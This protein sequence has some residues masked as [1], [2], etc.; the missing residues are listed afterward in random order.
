MASLIAS[1]TAMLALGVNPRGQGSSMTPHV[2]H[3]VGKPAKFRVGVGSYA[4]NVGDTQMPGHL[5]YLKHLP[6]LAA[7]GEGDHDVVVAHQPQV[8]VRRLGRMNESAGVA[9][10]QRVAANLRAIW[11][12]LPIPVVNTLPEQAANVSTAATKSF[13][14]STARMASASALSTAR[15]RSC[16]WHICFRTRNEHGVMSPVEC[17]PQSR[18]S[19]FG[20]FTKHFGEDI[21]KFRVSASHAV[22]IRIMP[23]KIRVRP[24]DEPRLRPAR[25]FSGELAS[26]DLFPCAEDS[27]GTPRRSECVLP[28]A[29]P[30]GSYVQR[31][32]SS[33]TPFGKP[34]PSNRQLSIIRMWA[35]EAGPREMLTAWVQRAYSC[36]P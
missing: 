32:K 2:E 22:K 35:Q 34:R 33:T 25:G 17:K 18:T 4:D 20:N 30:A 13:V 12:A 29:R 15:M 23:I 27:G 11:P 19:T 8:A 9:V 10:E 16:T 7:G 31:A 26:P 14:T 6:A 5:Q 28:A 1:M 36:T 3:Q 21:W 24:I